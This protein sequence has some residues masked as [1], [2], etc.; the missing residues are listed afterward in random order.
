MEGIYQ[1]HLLQKFKVSKIINTRLTLWLTET[2]V[3]F[4]C[5][6]MLHVFS[7]ISHG[8]QPLW[9]W[10][11]RQLPAGF[12]DPWSLQN[13]G[14]LSWHWWGW[15]GACAGYVTFTYSKLTTRGSSIF[16]TQSA[17]YVKLCWNIVLK[18]HLTKLNVCQIWQIFAF[19]W[20]LIKNLHK[21][22]RNFILQLILKFNNFVYWSGYTECEI[23]V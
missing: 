11:L 2:K 17:K 4:K 19:N 8:P 20:T 22:F 6:L 21:M 9:R 13:G 18:L 12:W 5:N 1:G 3:N 14:L 7:A 16:E 15:Q 23:L 10:Q